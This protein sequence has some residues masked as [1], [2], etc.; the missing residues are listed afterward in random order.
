[1]NF[2]I[3]CQCA[4]RPLNPG[5]SG[6]LPM[7][8][9]D[10]FPIFFDYTDSTGAFNGIN[11]GDVINQAYIQD[12]L[13]ETDLTKRWYIF[14]EMFNLEAPASENETED[15]DGISFPTGEQIKQT[16]SFDHIKEAANPAL[17][18]S[19]DSIKCRDLGVIYITYNGQVTG[20]SDGSGNL[21]G[22][23]V[24]EGTL[25]ANFQQAVKGAVQKMMVSFTIDELEND[26]NRDFI[27]ASSISYAT[28]NWF[29]EQP[30]EVLVD[31]VSNSGQ[32]TIVF[33]AHS[34]FGQVFDKKP[35]EGLVTADFSYDEGSTPATVYDLTAATSEAVTVAESSSDP[36]RYTITITS[37]V[38]ALH[39]I[40]VALSKTGYNM[41]PFIVT[42]VA[43]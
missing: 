7:A 28:K 38:T 21:I 25:Q 4:G 33:D 27:P 13:N 31:V 23:H 26:A 34:L 39:R 8:G 40:Q 11:H 14:P 43:S 6:C 35:I 12:K 3:E 36:G 17:K 5:Q 41:R 22:M 18:A 15:I 16:T 20:M 29:A 10:K 9:R 32:D 2:E 24:Q 42:M 19:Y 30:V 1:M 37:P